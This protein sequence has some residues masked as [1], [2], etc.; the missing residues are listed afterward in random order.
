MKGNK[1]EPLFSRLSPNVFKSFFDLGLKY[2]S[3][4][5][6]RTILFATMFCMAMLPLL[7]AG[8]LGY[9]NYQDLLQKSEQ[10]QLEWQ[11]GGGQA[12]RLAR[13]FLGYTLHLVEDAPG[14]NLA[15]PVFD[16]ALALALPH[17]QRLLGYRLVR[18]HANP[19]L[20]ATLDV[21][22]HRT[23][24]GLDLTGSKT[25]ALCRFK[26]ELAERYGAAAQRQTAIAAFHLLAKLGSLGL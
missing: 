10:E 21:T 26:T 15:N 14:L 6:L 7:L 23:T 1:R 12:E 19:D 20:A 4:K 9:Y 5:Q 2:R 8:G 3:Y 11:L 17:F 24:C 16:V 13:N 18:K 22:R 25:T